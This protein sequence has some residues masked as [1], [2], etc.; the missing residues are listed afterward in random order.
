MELNVQDDRKIVEVWLTHEDEQ[1]GE[2]QV[3]LKALYRLY[4]EQKFTVAVFHSGTG[5]L[6]R[7]TSDLLCCNRK[8]LARQEVRR[9]RQRSSAAR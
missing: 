5:D 9:A 4:K 3:M 8:E 1:N 7:Q 6:T 2:L